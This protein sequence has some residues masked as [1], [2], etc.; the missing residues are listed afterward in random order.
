[1]PILQIVSSS[2]RAGKSTI[3]AALA[4]GL[5]SRGQSVQL[6]RVGASPGAAADAAAFAGLAYAAAPAAPVARDKVPMGGAALSII[7]LSAGEAPLDAPAIVVVRG[8]PGDADAALAKA[9]GP[10]LVG[11]VSTIV[12][13]GEIELVA[14][15]LTN[16]GLRPLAVLP[17]DARLAAPAV[18]DIRAALAADVLHEGENLHASIEN[19][20]VAP[21]FTDGAKTHFSRFAGSKAVLAPSYKTDLLLAAVEGGAACVVVTGGHQPSHYII[22]R[23][24]DEACTVLLAQHQTPAAVV[25]LGPVWTASAFSGEAK[26][27]AAYEL[28]DARL[29]WASLS[30]KLA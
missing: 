17:E 8:Y 19:V 12:T 29:D 11:S 26:A 10:K 9:L 16:A 30:K 6:L 7:E 25:A 13:A 28:L 24:R 21:V 23:V 15:D 22:D 14:R 4:R 20:L 27:D 18:A 2:P 1:M 3:A 5:A